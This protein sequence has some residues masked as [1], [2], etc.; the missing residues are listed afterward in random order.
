MVWISFISSSPPFYFVFPVSDF[1]RFRQVGI[2]I[3]NGISNT[4]RVTLPTDP[5]VSSGDL[6]PDVRLT[7]DDVRTD[8]TTNLHDPVT[9]RPLTVLLTVILGKKIGNSDLFIMNR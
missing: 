1:V 5:S 7:S 6:V 4:E 2:F 3:S 8:V 9:D